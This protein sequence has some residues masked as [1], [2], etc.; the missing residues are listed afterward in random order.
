ME[1][2]GIKTEKD[3]G[4]LLERVEGFHDW[5]VAEFSYDPLARAEDGSLNLGRF[6][7]DVDSLTVTFRWDNKSKGEEWPEV[8][9]KFDG[10]LVFRFD[11]YKDPDPIWHG[12]IERTERGWVFFDDDDVA[13]TDTE[14]AHP[15][16]I[17]SGL[18][19]MCDQIRWRPLA[20]VTPD[21]PD[22]WND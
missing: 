6:K 10:L 12:R 22:W 20:V 1:W 5:Y 14:R 4:A 18:L 7:T 21:G 19:V 11:N 3:A 16:R 2:M 9:L 13:F 15:E 17:N 8:Q